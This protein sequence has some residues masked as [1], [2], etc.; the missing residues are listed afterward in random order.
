MADIRELI[1]GFF[2]FIIGIYVIKE[3]VKALNFEM[4]SLFIGLFIAL[5]IAWFIKEVLGR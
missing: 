4:G 2:F 1:G 5:G 3:I